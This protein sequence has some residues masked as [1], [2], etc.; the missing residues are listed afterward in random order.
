MGNAVAPSGATVRLLREDELAAADRNFRLAF[1]TFLAL[2]DPL[3]FAGDRDYIRHRW[4]ANPEAAFAAELDGE[5]AGSNFVVHWGS[6]G[7]FGPITIRPELWDK[8]IG[9]SLLEP[10]IDSFNRWGTVHGGLFTFPQSTKH[11]HLYRKFGFYPR[12]LTAITSKPVNQSNER[13]AVRYSELNDEQ[14]AEALTASRELTDSI[15]VG[16]DVTSEIVSVANQSLGDTV[17]IYDGARLAGFAVCHCG[18]GTEAG[19]GVC[20]FKFAAVRPGN[21]AGKR[22]EHLLD[23]CEKLATDRG[24]KRLVAGVNLARTGAFQTLIDHG[25]RVDT[26]G[27]SMARPNQPGYDRPDAYVLDDW[28]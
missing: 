20:Y 23:A 16:L 22:L 4:R 19:S 18:P 11:I 10:V 8:G 25:F 5:L 27:V 7:Y 24:L 21:D 2:P 26:H 6:V 17:L 1:G 14:R 9:K 15:F 28:R 3:Q 12:F 13:E